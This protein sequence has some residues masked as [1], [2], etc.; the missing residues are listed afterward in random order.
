MIYGSAKH[1]Q[2][3]VG[4]DQKYI[5]IDHYIMLVPIEGATSVALSPAPVPV[6]EPSTWLVGLG[7]IAAATIQRRMKLSRMMNL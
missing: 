1:T 5:G 7:L 6:P 4:R 3:R 2:W